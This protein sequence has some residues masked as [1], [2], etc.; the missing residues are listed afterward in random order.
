MI[1]ENDHKITTTRSTESVDLR[2]CN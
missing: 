2:Q 1:Y